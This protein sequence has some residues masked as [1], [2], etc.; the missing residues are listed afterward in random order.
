[1]SVTDSEWIAFGVTFKIEVVRRVV[2]H[3]ETVGKSVGAEGT[4]ASGYEL[5][6]SAQVL[7]YILEQFRC[8]TFLN[9]EEILLYPIP[10]SILDGTRGGRVLDALKYREDVQTFDSPERPD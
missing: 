3:F 6:V 7:D 9:G 10:R 2:K 4:S 8:G 1:M 5:Y